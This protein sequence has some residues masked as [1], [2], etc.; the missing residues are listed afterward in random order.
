[1]K[2]YYCN[3]YF[4]ESFKR[5]LTFAIMMYL[6]QFVMLVKINSTNTLSVA[7]LSYVF[8]LRISDLAV[9]SMMLC[10]MCKQAQN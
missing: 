6:F 2:K 10:F 1:M 7:T 5:L 3:A 4:L 8:S 9:V